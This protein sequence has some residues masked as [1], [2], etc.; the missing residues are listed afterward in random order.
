[1]YKLTFALMILAL[2][3]CAISNTANSNDGHLVTS[4]IKPSIEI[5]SQEANAI[6]DKSAVIKTLASDFAWTEGPL[7]L[8]KEGYLIFSDIPNNKIMKYHPLEGVSVY[9]ENSGSTGLHKGDH[10][11]GSN[12]LLLDQHDNLILLQQGDRRIAVM[13]A[14]TSSPSNN[15]KTLAGYYNGKRLNS[16]NDA[17]LHSDGSLFFTDPPYGLKDIMDD[18]RKELTF[19]GI[20]RL[21]PD[22]N[23][24]LLDDKI[25]FPNGIAISADEK[26]LYVAVSD[27][28]FPHWLAYDLSSDGKV[29]NKRVLIDASEFIG[30]AGEQGMP[31]GMAVHSSGLIFAT[32]PGGVW[33]ITP[34]G[35]VL[36]KIKTGK[37]TANCTLSADEK[38]L[39]LTAHNTLM[40]VALK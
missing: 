14:P 26:T 39:Y 38:T 22:G 18:K 7:W 17:V 6:L 3:S 20:Y 28:S 30:V 36:A 12:G 15:F 25:S 40:S 23:L 37:L 11:Q 10:T 24:Q 2:T 21:A 34:K 29:S 33:L 31:D 4:E 16:P 9:L 5:I 35:K 32:G 1:M 13:N 27:Q 19:Q 8:T